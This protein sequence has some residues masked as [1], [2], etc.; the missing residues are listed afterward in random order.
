MGIGN[1]PDNPNY[2]ASY[3]YNADGSI[4]QE[5]LNNSSSQ[6]IERNF[7]YNSPGWPEQIDN[8]IF[9]ETMSYT[10]GGYSPDGG[11]IGYYSGKTAQISS[12]VGVSN[13]GN[14]TTNFAYKYQY[15]RAGRLQVAQNLQSGEPFLPYSLG[16]SPQ[17]PTSYDDDGNIQQLDYGN[18][19]TGGEYSYKT[20]GY[21][22]GSNQLESVS[23]ESD[24]ETSTENFTAD[25][26]GNVT[27][28]S[29]KLQNLQYDPLTQMTASIT[30]VANSSNPVTF[31]YSGSQQR[32]LK[33]QSDK[34]KLYLHGE[35]SSSL[36]ER[37]KTGAGPESVTYYIYGPLGLIAFAPG[38]TLGNTNFL[39]VLKDRQG[40]TRAV[41][42]GT[43]G[44][45]LAAYNYLPFGDLMGEEYG[46]SV[47]AYRYTG[48]EYD[49]ETGLYNYQ[50]R[51]YDSSLGRFYAPDPARQ[52]A[53]PYLYAGNNPISM[54]DPTGELAFLAIIA[55]GAAI[56]AA[57]GAGVA[58]Y[59]GIEQDLSGGDLAG[60]IFAGAALGALTGA[61]SAAG[62]V[63]AFG[64]GSAAAAA[65]ATT[66]TAAGSAIGTAAGA[67][68]GAT[69]GAA[70]GA[71]QAAAQ[72]GI[73]EA[74]GVEN[75]GS[76]SD[77]VW[78]GAVV[79]GV[80]GAISGGVAGYGGSKYLSKDLIPTTKSAAGKLTSKIEQVSE[81]FD[82]F[83]STQ[84]IPL[85]GVPKHSQQSLK[86]NPVKFAGKK[87]TSRGTITSGVS[88]IGKEVTS[89]SLSA[90]TETTE[91]A[92]G[93]SA[94]DNST[95]SLV[96]SQQAKP[97]SLYYQQALNSARYLN[98]SRQA[99]YNQRS[100]KRLMK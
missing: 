75:Q 47:L 10:T 24:T 68:V 35:N 91:T 44:E 87:L 3:S 88:A 21:P 72:F 29:G 15:D 58:I 20:Y 18:E 48:Q 77:A 11:S 74:F 14:F 9:Q 27:A 76:L 57:L 97:S 53:S 40:S 51:L 81:A 22:G 85:P 41:V 84:K 61:L 32:V 49:S 26:N 42:D 38:A 67:G 69:V 98:K 13:P 93:S 96:S 82:E 54:V 62:G 92:A 8:E 80:G 86:Q 70:V 94:S 30:P 12:V 95:S 78:Q 55:I 33:Q 28:V 34:Q 37:D 66:G 7:T 16:L 6:P 71:G 89:T 63:A 23:V 25:G 59:T 52:F 45:V 65:T 60:Y 36:I 1:A 99:L 79:G 19:D 2:Y 64:A 90:L 4:Q 5:S 50:A 100:R 43:T 31:T 46:S 56:G 83:T 39:Y 73:N 17:G